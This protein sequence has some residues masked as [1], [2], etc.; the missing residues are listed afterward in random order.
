MIDHQH[1]PAVARPLRDALDARAGRGV[2]VPDRVEQRRRLEPRLRLLAVGVGTEQQR[3]PGPHLG[4]PV[5]DP[6]GAQREAGVHV[7][8]ESQIPD[9]ASV[10]APRRVLVVLDELDCVL[11]RRPGDRDRPRMGEEAVE[12]VVTFAQPSLDVVDGVDQSRVHLDL[13]PP[14]HPHAVRFAHA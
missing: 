11:L 8:V 5:L 3:R 7:A 14:D 6:H 9:R 4:D 10:P 1:P 12:R 2:A 13:A